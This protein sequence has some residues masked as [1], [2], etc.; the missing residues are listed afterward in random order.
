M[1]Q[2][3]VVEDLVIAL[4]KKLGTTDDTGIKETAERILDLFGYSDEIIDNVLTSEERDLFYMLE[5]EGFLTTREE[6]VK[7]KKGKLWRI[8]YWILNKQYILK[9][10]REVD[11]KVDKEKEFS[12]YDKI[13]E[14]VWKRKGER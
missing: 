12:I 9:L 10:A 1:S 13:P 5:E 6:E 3:V 14:E 4:K 11:E 7:L 8:H 2:I